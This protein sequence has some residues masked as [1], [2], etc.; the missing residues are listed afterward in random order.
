MENILYNALAGGNLSSIIC[1]VIVYF[2]ISYQRKQTGTQRYTEIE[3]MKKDI[4]NLKEDVSGSKEDIKE[5]HPKVVAFKLLLDYIGIDLSPRLL[6]DEILRT[7]ITLV[8]VDLSNKIIDNS[9]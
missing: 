9:F 1:A 8:L 5:I 4:S 3:L 7:D 6:D 2:I